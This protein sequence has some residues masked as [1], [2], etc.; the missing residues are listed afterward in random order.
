MITLVAAVAE[1]GI[2]GRDGDLPWHLPDD[3]RHFKAATLGTTLIVGRRTFESFGG[4]LPGRT[5]IVVTRQADYAAA[6]ATTA[7]SLDAAIAAAET[8][9]IAIGGGAAIYAEGLARA[10]QLDLTIVHAQPTG[11]TRFP[12]ID[13]DAWTL[14]EESPHPADDRH[15]HAFTI[16]R[17][18]RAARK[19]V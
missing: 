8:E 9:V 1:N 19:S 4:A 17:Y 7:L 13:W 14:V 15:A 2:I 10:D 3:L 18:I 5:T 6:G 16:R 12:E 11:D